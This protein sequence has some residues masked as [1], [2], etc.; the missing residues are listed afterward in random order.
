MQ[1]QTLHF[2]SL[3]HLSS[4]LKLPRDFIAELAKNGQLPSLN[5]KGRLRF[6]LETVKHALDNLAAKV[7]CDET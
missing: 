7:R 1:K 4:E 6:N 5:V 2:I 3:T